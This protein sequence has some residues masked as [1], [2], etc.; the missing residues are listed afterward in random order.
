[1]LWGFV[2]VITI[3]GKVTVITLLCSITVIT[4]LG[5]IT[6]ITILGE[7]ILGTVVETLSKV[8][9]RN[10]ESNLGP[11]YL[12]LSALPLSLSSP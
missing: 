3:L 4:I 10:C 1:M 7:G 5:S 11:L 2:T 8:I 9:C 12:E 6:L